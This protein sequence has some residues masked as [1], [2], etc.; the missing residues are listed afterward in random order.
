METLIKALEIRKKYNKM[1]SV[2][3]FTHKLHS[4]STDYRKT[5]K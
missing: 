3:K 5:K 1:S 4:S 2:L